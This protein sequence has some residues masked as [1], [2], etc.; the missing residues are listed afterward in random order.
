MRTRL[1]A[2]TII[3][4]ILIWLALTTTAQHGP[5]DDRREPSVAMFLHVTGVDGEVA[6]PGYEGWI[7]VDS[8]NYGVTRSGRL[9]AGER[10][11]P[12][13]HRGLTVT[14]GPDKATPLLYFHAS[15]GEPI[16]EVA[17]AVVRST[18]DGHISQEYRLRNALVTSIQ[19]GGTQKA[20]ARGSERVTFAY[21]AIEWVYV[22]SDP[23]TGRLSSEVSVQWDRETL[24]AD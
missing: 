18:N 12:A 7:A 15:S 22:K 17:L 6:E 24:H 3:A 16:E 11:D 19:T 5:A 13:N 14:K 23:L 20:D 21:Q 4:L 1:P 8:F 10:P 2:T 9:P